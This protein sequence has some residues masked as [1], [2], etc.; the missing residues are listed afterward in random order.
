MKKWI[1]IVSFVLTLLLVINIQCVHASTDSLKVNQTRNGMHVHL[2]KIADQSDDGYTYTD[3]F[4]DAKETSID[5]NNLKNTEDVL[6]AAQ[7]FKGLAA[8]KI[9]TDL[10]ATG[11][12]LYFPSLTK[13]VYLLLIDNYTSGDTTYSYLPLLIAFP[14]TNEVALTKYSSTTIHK[15]SLVKHWNGGRNYPKSI[16]VDLYNGKKLEKTLTLSK[17]NNY[18]YS[19]TTTENKDYSIKEHQVQGYSSS[20]DVSESNDTQSFIL[21][22]TKNPVTVTS[23]A[24]NVPTDNENNADQSA[25]TATYQ[26]GK[27]NVKTSNSGQTKTNAESS[28]VKPTS[29]QSVKTGDETNINVLIMIFITA[30]IALMIIGRFLKN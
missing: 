24:D 1:R 14:E 22:N 20:V 18:A 12:V 30:G 8:S 11:N 15:Y 10:I 16:Q 3:A 2:Y 29:T 6:Q 4:G 21:T 23:D 19:W 28:N 5:L 25:D 27:G 13:G 9:G 7:T 26:G 17:E